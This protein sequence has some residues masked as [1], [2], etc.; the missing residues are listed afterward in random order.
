MKNK[1]KLILLSL[2]SLNCFAASIAHA[3]DYQ[4]TGVK[5]NRGAKATL[6]IINN[7][8]TFIDLSH[9]KSAAGELLPAVKSWAS[10]R[11]RSAID[12]NAFSISDSLQKTGAGFASGYTMASGGHPGD[13]FSYVYFC[14]KLVTR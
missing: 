6:Q 3:T 9:N 7:L 12:Y 14:K 8:A 4:C 5:A 1:C 11:L 13:T 2:I 10:I